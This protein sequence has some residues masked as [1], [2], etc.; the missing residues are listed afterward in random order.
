LS[1]VNGT[2]T[3]STVSRWEG[4]SNISY[5]PMP[6]P[7]PQG[8]AGSIGGAG[9]VAAGQ[10]PPLAPSASPPSASGAN[11]SGIDNGPGLNRKRGALSVVEADA[12][13]GGISIGLTMRETQELQQELAAD[14]RFPRFHFNEKNE[15]VVHGCEVVTNAGFFNTHNTDCKGTLIS[16]GKTIAISEFK[17]A[18]FGLRGDKVI[19]VLRFQNVECIHFRDMFQIMC[20]LHRIP[21]PL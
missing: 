14:S 17:T 21:C 19:V 16:Q 8:D 1:T 13:A 6:I 18:H 20:I 10:Q 2:V 15:Q 5:T 11:S 3:N 4:E 7:N 9:G 12:G